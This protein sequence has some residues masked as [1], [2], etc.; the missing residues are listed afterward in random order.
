M[1]EV[2]EEATA[3]L[4]TLRYYIDYQAMARDPEIMFG[5]GI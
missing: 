2:T 4:Q 5:P 1:Q 3:I